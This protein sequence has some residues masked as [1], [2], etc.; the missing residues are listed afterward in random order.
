MQ[1]IHTGFGKG[2]AQ[3]G[4]LVLALI[5]PPALA[6]VPQETSSL[7]DFTITL[8]LHPFLTPEELEVMRLVGSD[9]QLLTLF[10]PDATGHSALA[11]S[12]DEGF[13]KE[14]LPVP[15]AFALGGLPDTETAGKAAIAGC[16]KAAT[17]KTPCVVILHVAPK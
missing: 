17:S 14:G 6:E 15:S 10:V 9:M 2:A 4:A 5:A 12:P 11:V 1:A 7:G 13:V 3:M 16:Q 8:Q